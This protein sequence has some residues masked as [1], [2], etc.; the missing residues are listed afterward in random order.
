M[1][2][3]RAT[4]LGD[5][6]EAGIVWD[7]LEVERSYA[8]LQ[9]IGLHAA[10]I[11][12]HQLNFGELFGTIQGALQTTA[13]LAA[14]RVFDR[15]MRGYETHRVEAVLDFM[16]RHRKE[17]GPIVERGYAERQFERSGGGSLGGASDEEITD[18]IVAHFRTALEA[19]DVVDAIDRL[20]EM[21]DKRI[22]HNERVEKVRSPTWKAVLDLLAFAKNL[23]GV[24]G[25][26]YLARVYAGDDVKFTL[27]TDAQR[28]SRA[29]DRLLKQLGIVPNPHPRPELH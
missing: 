17:I 19:S 3:D 22:A 12:G 29:M 9:T 15:K 7:V 14:A 26:A 28:P 24:I 18:A 16:A 21:R 5:M 10:E 25:W 11:N 1:P 4:E 8:L 20:R 23:I 13:V 2:S 27:D 6:L